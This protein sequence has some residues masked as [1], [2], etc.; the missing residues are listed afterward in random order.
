M[1]QIDLIDSIS[2]EFEVTIKKN[3]PDQFLRGGGSSAADFHAYF[4][5][6]NSFFKK[7]EYYYNGDLEFFHL[8]SYQNLFSILNSWTIRMY[9]LQKS[10]DENE[11]KFSAKLFK[12]SSEEIEFRKSRI[13]SFSCC[14][15]NELKNEKIWKCYGKDFE[16][17]A[18]VFKI[19]ND[20]EK[21]DNFHMSEIKYQLSAKVK[22]Y[23]EDIE[24][25]KSKYPYATFDL[26]LEKLMAFHKEPKWEHEKEVRILTHLTDFTHAESLKRELVIEKGRNR[27]AEYFDLHLGVDNG[28]I[29]EKQVLPVA[30]YIIKY[31]KIKITKVLFGKN[32]GLSDEEYRNVYC[33]EIENIVLRNFGYSITPERKLFSIKS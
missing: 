32:C 2:R 9:N 6:E 13:F 29:D 11:Y 19:E 12:A 31:P 10:I 25:L 14:P 4:A 5:K 16:G 21:W 30:D 3:F 18:I 26:E 17:V 27:F 28:L 33:P 20:L 15:I 23:V 22:Q 24:Q 7:T 8:T 1:N